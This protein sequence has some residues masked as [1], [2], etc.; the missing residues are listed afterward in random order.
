M[1]RILLLFSVAAMALTMV[2][3]LGNGRKAAEE[4]VEEP[5]PVRE[6]VDMMLSGSIGR[7]GITMHLELD[8]NGEYTGWYYYN[9]NGSRNKLKL[10][11]REDVD[12]GMLVLHEYDERDIK[13]GRFELV[14]KENTLTGDLYVLSTARYFRVD[15]DVTDRYAYP[16]G[17]KKSN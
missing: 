3:C 5:V 14:V 12:K 15:L 10:Y 16:A 7:M 1:R 17:S 13:T 2:S 9:K 8:E 6:C 11:G 4:P